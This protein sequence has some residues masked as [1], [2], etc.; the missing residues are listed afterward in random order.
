VVVLVEE[1]L[2][3]RRAPV[4]A[5]S[6]YLIIPAFNEQENIAQLFADLECRPELHELAHSILIVDDGSSD[7]TPELIG[8]Y[9]GPLPIELLRFERNKGPGA[10]FR[11]GFERVLEQASDDAFVVTLEAD[12]TGDLEALPRLLAA[13]AAGAD[14]VLADW[15]MQN[16]S[17]H[18]RM[19]SAAAGFVVR[20][21]L[22]IDA[23]T[24]SSFYRV[25]RASVLRAAFA[26]HGENLIRESGFACKAE[27]LA[28]LAGMGARIVAV[29][30]ALDWSRRSG[31][32]KMPVMKTMIAYWRMLFRA[33]TNETP[34][35]EPAGL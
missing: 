33:R 29:P 22:G 3:S 16:V 19:C 24:V 9:A 35:P 14:V 32:S 31:E 34:A 25:Y 11:E 20:R 8:A 21:A 2:R 23:K 13:A 28:K 12:G 1:P 6:L 17:A 10:A 26:R 30:V 27:I 18:R 5:A 4:Q 15:K 7:L